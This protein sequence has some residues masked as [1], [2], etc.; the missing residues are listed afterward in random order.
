MSGITSS[1]GL[2]SGIDSATLIEQLLAVEARP[3]VLANQRIVGL[4]LIQTSYLD[5]AA[6]M[7]GLESAASAFRTAGSIFQA[8]SAASSNESSIR[9]TATNNTPQGTFNFVVDRLVTTQQLLSRGFADRDSSPFGASSFTFESE[10]G[11]LTTDALLADLNS[12]GGVRRGTIEFTQDGETTRV[13]LS[14]AATINEVVNAIN[15]AEDLDVTASINNGALVLTSSGAE[16]TVANANGSVGVVEDLGIAGSSTGGT[17]TGSALTGLSGST[18]LRRLNDGNGVFVGTDSGVSRYDFVINV[19]GTDVQINIGGIYEE[20]TE[21]D[22]TTIELVEP[23]PTDVAGVMERINSQLADAGFTEVTVSID[24]QGLRLEDTSGRAITVS[25]KNATSRTAKHLGLSGSNA[26]GLI[27]GERLVAGLGTVLL[28]NLNGGSGLTGDGQ[29]DFTTRNGGAFSID[30]SSA[31]TVE[32]IMDLVNNDATN[33]GRIRLS[34]NN[35]GNGLAVTD[36]TGGGGNLIIGGDAAT[37]LGI[38][39]DPAGTASNSVRGNNL[40]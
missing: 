33:A 15:E 35:A 20:V 40:Q 6:R 34:L 39:T 11:K 30:L 25:E 13:D 17:L 38:A 12:G 1:V 26:G 9:A 19:G 10:Q 5:L 21:D 4:Q 24:G 29:I 36:T 22:V 7:R 3:K 27:V 14:R 18:L 2:I 16:F 28:K 8:K 37:S 23:A 31:Q 32:D